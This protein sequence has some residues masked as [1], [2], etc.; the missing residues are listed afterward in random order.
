MCNDI[1]MRWVLLQQECLVR[2]QL[3]LLTI[4]FGQNSWGNRLFNNFHQNSWAEGRPVLARKKC[5]REA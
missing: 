2:L 4:P 5:K 1:A 3:S